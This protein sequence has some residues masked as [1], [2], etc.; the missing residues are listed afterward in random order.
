VAPQILFPGSITDESNMICH[1]N[2]TK[3]FTKTDKKNI[4]TRRQNQTTPHL[5]E[6]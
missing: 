1:S 2:Q 5:G 3:H 6:K 4:E